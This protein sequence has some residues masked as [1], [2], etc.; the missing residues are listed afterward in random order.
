MVEWLFGTGYPGQA[1][2]LPGDSESIDNL[3]SLLFYP[4]VCPGLQLDS[5][6]TQSATDI[7][8]KFQPKVDFTLIVG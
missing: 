3:I 5:T 7:R 6:F 1:I 4:G 8:S 2:Y